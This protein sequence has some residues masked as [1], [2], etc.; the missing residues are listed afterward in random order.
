MDFIYMDLLNEYNNILNLGKTSKFNTLKEFEETSKSK[1][2]GKKIQQPLRNLSKAKTLLQ[3]ACNWYVLKELKQ[4][5]KLDSFNGL[6]S[7]NLVKDSLMVF[8]K[9]N[10]ARFENYIKRAWLIEEKASEKNDFITNK[11]HQHL[12]VHIEKQKKLLDLKFV[13]MNLYKSEEIAAKHL[14]QKLSLEQ[15]FLFF[16]D[17]FLQIISTEN[18]GDNISNISGSVVD[19]II[20]RKEILAKGGKRRVRFN[21]NAAIQNASSCSST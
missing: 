17:S 7:Q 21:T 10:H 4:Y 20:H 5:F 16:L 8:R 6:E 15:K 12:M 19:F 13:K 3:N 9:F 14:W 11:Y 2:K 1:L 18:F